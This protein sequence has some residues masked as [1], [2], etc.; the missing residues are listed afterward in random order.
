[1]IRLYPSISEIV[2]TQP[3]KKNE[4]EI[5]TTNLITETVNQINFANIEASKHGCVTKEV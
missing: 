1:M 2:T 4:K 5:V 3:G